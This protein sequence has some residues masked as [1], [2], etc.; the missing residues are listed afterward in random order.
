MLTI[1]SKTTPS[2]ATSFLIEDLRFAPLHSQEEVTVI[3]VD[4]MLNLRPEENPDGVIIYIDS[5]AVFGQWCSRVGR[6]RFAPPPD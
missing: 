4:A 3:S 1:A 5:L 2:D 6:R